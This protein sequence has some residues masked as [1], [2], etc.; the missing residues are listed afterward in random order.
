MHIFLLKRAYYICVIALFDQTAV[1]AIN[2][3]SKRC[4]SDFLSLLK[5]YILFN[6][7]KKHGLYL[8]DGSEDLLQNGVGLSFLWPVGLDFQPQCTWPCNK[9]KTTN[10]KECFIRFIS[11]NI[12]ACQLN[13]EGLTGCIKNQY[14]KGT[15]EVKAQR[16]VKEILLCAITADVFPNL[17]SR[18]VKPHRP[19]V[20]IWLF[21]S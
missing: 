4:C 3:S 2:N 16:A 6:C 10:N 9:P 17:Q 7:G 15:S 8:G 14:S 1:P 18:R 13:A 5:Q 21:C 19:A 11:C 20:R 12:N